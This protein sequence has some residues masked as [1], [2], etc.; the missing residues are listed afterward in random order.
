MKYVKT[1]WQLEIERRNNY[2]PSNNEYE[3]VAENMF[4]KAN[5]E[6]IK[7]LYNVYCSQPHPTYSLVERCI[8]DL[9]GSYRCTV[10]VRATSF[11]EDIKGNFEQW[12]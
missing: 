3:Q 1:L 12:F 11:D 8:D 9:G 4:R 10:P 2:N 7:N 5:E 6:E